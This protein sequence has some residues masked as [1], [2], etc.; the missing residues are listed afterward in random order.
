MK[1]SSGVRLCATAAVSVLSLALITG[2]SEG[3][4]KDSGDGKG[5]E[6]AAKAL[7]AAELKQLIIAKG[8]VPGYK[9][10]PVKGGIPNKNKVKSDDAQCN[11]ALR[12]LI[13]IAPGEPAA[14]TSRM[15]TED[16]KEPTDK[17]TSLND[18]TNGKF[19]DALNES[20]DLDITVVTLA[21]YDGDGAESAL[22]S[23]S[24]AVKD[25]SGGFSSKQGDFTKVAEEKSSGTG[26][27][28]VA[29][30]A[31]N[32]AG[33]DGPL[34]LHAEVVRHGNTLATYTTINIGAMMS[35]KAYTVSAPV[36]KAQAAKLK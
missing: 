22:K 18:L 29:F 6:S 20:M 36:I 10:G 5:G 19:E 31:T 7:S 2:C 35:K 11:P 16:K 32:D 34:A 33:K 23:V 28:S 14:N 8:E 21:S 15:A 13:G 17:A 26:D 12:A 24:D 1:R 4:S 9:V 3:G 27:A 30:T 25:C